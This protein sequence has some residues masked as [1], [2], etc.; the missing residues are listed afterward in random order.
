[1]SNVINGTKLS[2]G[3]YM[4]ELTTEQMDDL[5][6][7]Y[8]MRSAKFLNKQ[9]E[10]DSQYDKELYLRISDSDYDTYKAIKKIEGKEF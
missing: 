2:N 3:N 7:F 5:A 4:I 9:I 8:L 1:M 6:T 10:S